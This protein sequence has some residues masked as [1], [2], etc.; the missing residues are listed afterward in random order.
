MPK[1]KKQTSKK[2]VK[3]KNL[4]LQAGAGII[5]LAFVI[6]FVLFQLIMNKP[7]ATNDA[8]EN[9]VG[10]YTA[11]SFQKNGELSFTTPKDTFIS[12]IDIE[13]ADTDEKRELGLMYR[14]KMAE[15]QGMLFIFPVEGQQ[16]FWMHN[17]IISLDMIFVNASMEIVKIQKNTTPYSDQS[18]P[19]VKPAKYVIEV[20]AGYCDRHGIK[21]GDKIAWRI[22]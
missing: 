6:Y 13:I 18:Y 3:K 20:N 12:Q 4:F 16:S 10:N 8:L 7:S 21:E 1:N 19:S 5:L 15:N 2:P 11:Y 14:N 17:T 9:A 22:L